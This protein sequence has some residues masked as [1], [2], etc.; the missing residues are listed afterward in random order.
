[1]IT[2]SQQSLAAFSNIDVEHFWIYKCT[3][4]M[5]ILI[6]VCQLLIW[7][8]LGKCISPFAEFKA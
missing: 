5:K 6:D 8:I 3:L 2:K 4:I 7:E 1:M